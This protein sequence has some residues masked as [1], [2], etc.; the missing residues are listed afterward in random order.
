MVQ[1]TASPVT[2]LPSSSKGLTGLATLPGSFRRR[3]LGTEWW[4][5][6]AKGDG[7][8]ISLIASPDR[9]DQVT[10][11]RFV[12]GPSVWR[13]WNR[14]P[15]VAGDLDDAFGARPLGSWLKE[16]S[17]YREERRDG[18]TMPLRNCSIPRSQSGGFLRLIE[19]R[20]H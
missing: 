9:I 15:F 20:R 8:L 18:V 7:R 6:Q 5:N 12:V 14:G 16:I 13:V 2:S 1:V 11:A 17:V 3:L 10:G 19:S 4:D